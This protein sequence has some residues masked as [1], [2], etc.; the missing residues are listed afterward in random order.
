MIEL[1][2]AI[3]SLSLLALLLLAVT[4]LEREQRRMLRGGQAPEAHYP[5]STVR[6]R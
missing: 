1:T 5:P 4:V 3:A 6:F 2:I